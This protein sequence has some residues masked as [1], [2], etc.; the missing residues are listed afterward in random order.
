[1]KKTLTVLTLTVLAAVASAAPENPV[2]DL[3]D[4]EITFSLNFDDSTMNADMANGKAAPKRIRSKKTTFADKGLFGKA[5]LSGNAEYDAK[6]NLDLTVPGTLIYWIAPVKWTTTKPASGKEPGFT[7]F[8]GI[9]RAKDYGFEMVS[10]K[11]HGQ[12][13]GAGHF[14]TYV[15]YSAK[16][17]I[18]HVNR[19]VY[20]QARASSWKNGM[21]KMI[22]V[23]WGGGKFAV[24]INGGRSLSSSLNKLMTGKTNYFILASGG[25]VMLDEVTILNRA[26]TDAEIKKLYDAVIKA[27][28][29][30]N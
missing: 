16:P 22:A 14:N 12:P 25:T 11:M 6:L 24:S 15:Q 26:L 10:G 18:K 28:G 20:N 23:T 3:F 4:K 27:R 9:G 17:M 29:G 13:W 2:N 7:A 30:V 5:L 19:V 8:Y 21:W 1:M